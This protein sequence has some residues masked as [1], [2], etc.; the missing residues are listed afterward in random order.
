MK[1]LSCFLCKPVYE[2]WIRSSP[3]RCQV[4]NLPLQ[5]QHFWLSGSI[6]SE[7]FCSITRLFRNISFGCFYESLSTLPTLQFYFLITT[8]HQAGFHL[9]RATLCQA[10][11]LIHQQPVR[12]LS[13]LHTPQS[14]PPRAIPL[15]VTLL[16]CAVETSDI[17]ASL[18]VA[19]I[20]LSRTPGLQVT[21]VAIS[22]FN[23]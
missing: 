7:V 17:S 23:V 18:R 12:Q 2:C 10:Y 22:M 19:K 20:T 9:E 13:V 16:R 3:V 1:I 8:L 15:L 6:S 4:D 14:C 11:H 5:H 21:S